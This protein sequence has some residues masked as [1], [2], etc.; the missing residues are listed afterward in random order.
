VIRHNAR[1][2][3]DA[4]GRQYIMMRTFDFSIATRRIIAALVMLASCWLMIQPA[5]AM[6]VRERYEL[7]QA[8]KGQAVQ[9]RKAK[10][11]QHH[12]A[13][14]HKTSKKKAVKAK[15]IKAKANKSKVSKAKARPV[16]VTKKK[17][18]KAKVIKAKANKSKVSTAKARPVKVSKKKVMKAKV[19]KAKTHQNTKP[20]RTT[21]RA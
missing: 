5:Q 6:S 12:T 3:F 11:T 20:R 4:L 10:A 14:S 13:T 17:A 7:E 16:K 9:P 15:V 19:I 18:V 8:K 2:R 1:L 21:H